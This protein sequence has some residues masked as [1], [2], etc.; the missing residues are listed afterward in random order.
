MYLY[1]TDGTCWWYNDDNEWNSTVGFRNDAYNLELQAGTYFLKTT[2]ARTSWYENKDY[3]NSTGS[4]VL[5]TKF[6]KSGGTEVEPN[7]NVR[8]ADQIYRDSTVK[9]HIAINDRYDFFKIVLPKSGRLTLDITAYMRYYSMYVYD[10]NGTELWKNEYNEWNSTVGFQNEV[11]NLDLLSGTYYVKITGARYAWYEGK[12][13]DNA[14]GNYTLKSS[15]KSAGTNEVEPNNAVAQAKNVSLQAKVKGQIAIND[16]YD[17]FA[18][19]LNKDRKLFMDI[20]SYMRY[21]TLSVYDANGNEKC[22]HEYKEWNSAVG[23]REDTYSIDLPAG[24]YYIKVTGARAKYYEG[25][26]YDNSTGNYVLELN[27]VDPPEVKTSNYAASGKNKL[28]WES[29]VGATKYQVFRSNTK[30]GSYKRI[31]T[32]SQLSFVDKTAVAGKTYYYYVVSLNECGD[33]SVKSGIVSR[34]CDVARPEVKL[35]NVAASGKIKITWNEVKSAVKYQVFRSTT[36]NGTYKSIATTKGNSWV[37]KNAVAGK[38]YYYKVRALA[39]VAGANSALSAVKGAACDLAQPVITVTRSSVSGKPVI[40][41][42]AVD[43]ARSFTVLVSI[44]GGKTYKVL[45]SGIANNS[46]VHS[47]AQRGYYYTYQVMAV[48]AKSASNSVKS[49]AK[50]I[51][52]W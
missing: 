24:T 19:T 13:Y 18:V 33:K 40:S 34:M 10:I 51:T 12:D 21:Y 36:K 3:D 42:K 7:D 11:H 9:G 47:N 1:D 45:K 50:S 27:Q 29:V 5:K 2:G 49:V 35:S 41:W 26:D 17:F 28:T 15:F 43:N 25:K 32:T 23:Y 4:Y 46:F 44:N 38:V 39:S 52:S 6:V 31:G 8:L 37:D 30:G 16:R 48:S 22:Y 20:T 14:Y